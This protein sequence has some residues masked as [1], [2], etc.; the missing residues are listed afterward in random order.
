MP[1]LRDLPPDE[2]QRLHANTAVL[3]VSGLTEGCEAGCD[4]S[5][6]QVAKCS[7]WKLLPPGL[8]MFVY[9]SPQS[10][11]ISN[12]HAQ[13]RFVA[14]KEVMVRTWTRKGLQSSQDPPAKRR[15]TTSVAPAP[16]TVVSP[17][18]IKSADAELAPYPFDKAD[19]WKSLTSFV[20]I[21]CLCR[22]IGLDE[23]G[24]AVVDAQMPSTADEILVG[25]TK[26]WGKKR[27]LEP[28]PKDEQEELLQFV[29]FDLRRSWQEGSTGEELS[30]NARDKSWLLGQVLWRQLDS[31]VP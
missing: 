10:S 31:S 17:D 2:L 24:D 14:A 19:E 11:G 7:G 28:A 15:R 27:E 26:Q 16:A 5:L 23:N 22:V 1:S 13:L 25:Q 6:F 18:Y 21:A 4:G 30:R 12:R 29:K 8:H 20:D 3:L 9:S